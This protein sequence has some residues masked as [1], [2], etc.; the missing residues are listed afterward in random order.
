MYREEQPHLQGPL[1][2]EGF[3][4]FRQEHRT[5][6]DAGCV[7]QVD[8]RYYPAAPARLYSEVVVRVYAQEIEIVGL[9][10]DRAAPAPTIGASGLLRR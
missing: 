2:V 6:D 9:E 4:Y 1:P 8:A 5:V 10:R 3:R 7:V